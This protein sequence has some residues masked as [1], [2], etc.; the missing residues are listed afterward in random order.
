MRDMLRHAYPTVPV[1]AEEAP[2]YRYVSGWGR[3]G[4][5]A[6]ERVALGERDLRRLALELRPAVVDVQVGLVEPEHLR[7][8][9]AALVE[10]ADVVPDAH[11]A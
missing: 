2:N 1:G 11:G 3:R 8:E 7:V 10:V 6:V 9:P 4:D 5:A